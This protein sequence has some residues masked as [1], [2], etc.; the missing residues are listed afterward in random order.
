MNSFQNW[1]NGNKLTINFDPNKSCYNVFKPKNENLSSGYDRGIQTG[2]NILTYK[3][4]TK[5]LSIIPDDKVTW[6]AHI[7]E[8][9]CKIAKYAGIFSKVRFMMPRKCLTTLYNSFTFPKINYDIQTYFS[10]FHVLLI[11]CILH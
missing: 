7:P 1:I 6:M 5:Y 3:E 4:S 10:T 8:T 11:L 2:E 9:T